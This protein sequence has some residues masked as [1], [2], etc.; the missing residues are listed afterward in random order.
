M[1]P[2]HLSS[3]PPHAASPTR[4]LG[5]KAAQRPSTTDR[6]TECDDTRGGMSYTAVTSSDRPRDGCRGASRR[7]RAPSVVATRRSTGGERRRGELRPLRRPPPPRQRAARLTSTLIPSPPLPRHQK[8][9]Y[10][11]FCRCD[12]RRGRQQAVSLASTIL[13]IQPRMSVWRCGQ[14]DGMVG[15]RVVGGGVVGCVVR[16]VWR[17]GR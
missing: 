7:R 17:V 4:Q 14:C 6:A 11:L 1:L 2:L 13:H 5:L 9:C 8:G 10:A 12:R 15:C 3:V 16:R